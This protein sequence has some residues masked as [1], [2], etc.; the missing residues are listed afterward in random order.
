MA[1]ERVGFL[2]F[3]VFDVVRNAGGLGGRLLLLG[4]R[5]GAGQIRDTGEGLTTDPS[6][7]TVKAGQVRRSRRA[8]PLLRGSGRGRFGR[9]HGG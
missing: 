9:A 7:G 6:V 4:R 3:L 5:P 8:P 1:D 2:L